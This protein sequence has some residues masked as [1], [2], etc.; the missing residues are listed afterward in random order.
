MQRVPAPLLLLPPECDY[1]NW[2]RPNTEL[3]DSQQGPQRQCVGGG[4]VC[5]GV[6]VGVCG[7]VCVCVHVC[8]SCFENPFVS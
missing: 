2:W 3:K 1:C 4:P 6:S 8:V 5:L 7:G